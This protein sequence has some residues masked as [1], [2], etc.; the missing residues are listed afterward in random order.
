MPRRV[1][2]QPLPRDLRNWSFRW[3][4]CEGWDFSGRDL[5]GC[6]F[7]NT[8]LTNANFAG[9]LIGRSRQQNLRNAFTLGLLILI[10]GLLG[11]AALILTPVL[12]W[13]D[14]NTF[15][16]LST[17]LGAFL[18]AV[19]IVGAIGK[20]ASVP[21]AIP[22][23]FSGA[24]AGVIAASS[25]NIVGSF[26]LLGRIDFFTVAMVVGL[27]AI[28]CILVR[29]VVQAWRNSPGTNFKGATLVNANFTDVVG[30][31]PL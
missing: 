11:I 4:D 29:I 15:L 13:S 16:V 27:L 7:R 20:S 9:S 25:L 8:N 19:V 18:S 22:A 1:I 30:G 23:A 5:R 12:L 17:V 10:S 21:G 3:L 6:D 26:Q 14:A 28:F 31:D 24:L 2:S